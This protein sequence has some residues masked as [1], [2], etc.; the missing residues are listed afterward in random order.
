MERVASPPLPLGLRAGWWQR[1]RVALIVWW[2][3]AQLD[4]QLAAGASPRA[5]LVLAVRAHRIT[6]RRSRVRVADGLARA[7]RDARAGTRGFSAAVR[8]HRR[9][10][11]AARSVLDTIERRLRDRGPVAAR[12]V[13]MLRLLLIDGTSPLYRPTEPGALGSELRAAAAVLEPV[14]EGDRR[15]LR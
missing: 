10:M 8:P 3:A 6:T 11:L 13:A 1:T 12:G 2:R 7:F 9:E 15:A 14:D 4:R 5:S